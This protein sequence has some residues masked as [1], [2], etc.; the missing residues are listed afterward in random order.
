MGILRKNYN[1]FNRFFKNNNN[2]ILILLIIICVVSYLM[3]K[4][5]LQ[6]GEKGRASADTVKI[7]FN[8]N[9]LTS[10]AEQDHTSLIVVKPSSNITIQGYK[11]EIRFDIAKVQIKSVDYK[12]GSVSTDIG[13]DSSK[14]EIINK[15]G[16]IRIQGEIQSPEGYL[17]SSDHETEII[18][19]KF[20]PKSKDS[21]SITIDSATSWF[22]KINTDNTISEIANSNSA[23]LKI[24]SQG[25]TPNL[26][27]KFQ[28]IS[29]KPEE[30]VNKMNI[31]VVLVSD[32]GDIQENNIDFVSDDNGIWKGGVEFNTDET[33]KYKV[34]IKGPKH[35]QKRI[36]V[37]NPTEGNT[38][39]YSCAQTDDGFTISQEE[40]L[41][42][43]NIRILSGD[44]PENGKQNGVIDSYDISF[45]RNNLG[46]TEESVVNICDI[47]LDNICDTQDYSLLIQP[48]GTGN[49]YDEEY[50]E[51]AA[52]PINTPTSYAEST[53]TP[54]QAQGKCLAIPP[55]EIE[56][57]GCS[58][59]SYYILNRET[60]S[61]Q[62]CSGISAKATCL[63]CPVGECVC[64]ITASVPPLT[65]NC[66]NGGQIHVEL[67]N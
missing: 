19:L 26:L 23:K 48:L 10:E 15:T 4:Y 14:L 38:G 7:S 13:Q 58:T 67:C 33:E 62:E 54:Q 8:P 39:D 35:L 25:I 59:E 5:M 27:L 17:L 37:S 1:G 24:N 40:T 28:G 53:L 16:L 18:S 22:Y 20:T 36:C 31:K 30:S 3:A 2:K 44:L 46:K 21:T 63:N 50:T 32:T 52:A 12:I 47:N 65:V 51:S 55:A 49:K 45:I 57:L 42:F 56:I 9:S 11:M 29:R 41:D 64:N 60:S 66:T 34:Y 61:C 43:S 6:E